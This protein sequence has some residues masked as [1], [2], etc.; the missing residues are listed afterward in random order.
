MKIPA[1]IVKTQS[2]KKGYVYNKPLVDGKVKVYVVDE[3]FQLTGDKLLCLPDT[4]KV[5]GYKD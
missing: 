4:I 3:K 1:K 2:G 5:I